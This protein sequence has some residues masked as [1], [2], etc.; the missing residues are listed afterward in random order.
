MTVAKTAFVA[1]VLV[2]VS[3]TASN[4]R[5]SVAGLATSPFHETFAAAS[6]AATE[7][8]RNILL[9]FYTDW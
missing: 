8:G 7:A 1:L 6:T 5:V 2:I 4:D 9:D 3:C